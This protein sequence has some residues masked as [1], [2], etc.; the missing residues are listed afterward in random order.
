MK[1][2][3][4]TNPLSYTYDPSHKG[5][6]YTLDGVHY[7]N[8]GELCEVVDKACKGFEAVKDP[9]GRWDNTSDI[10]E[11]FTSVKSSRATLATDLKGDDMSKMLDEYFERVHST[12][13]DYVVML[14][15]QVIVYNMSAAEFKE[16][17][18][19]WASINE[20]KVIRFKK[21]GPAMLQWLEMRAEA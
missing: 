19:A 11:T 4:Y 9:S 17:T 12:N 6:P 7:M 5:A 8:G 18:E 16:F 10:T 3:T 13:W 21:T 1:R 20:R 15:E 14:D 2:N